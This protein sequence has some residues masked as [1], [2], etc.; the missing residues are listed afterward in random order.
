MWLRHCKRKMSFVSMLFV[1]LGFACRPLAAG[2]RIPVI[3]STDIGNEIDDQWMV[4]YALTSPELDVLGIVSAHAPM[5]SPPAG[6]TSYRILVDVVENRLGMNEHP[7]LFAGAS[8]P[9]RDAQTPRPNAGVDFII[10]ASKSFSKGNRLNVLA[11]GAVTDVASALLEDPAMADRIQIVNMGF[12]DWPNGEDD[13]NILNDVTAMQVILGSGTPLVVGSARVCRE[14]LGLTVDQARQMIGDRGPVG[15][16]LWEEFQAF[17]YRFEKPMRKNDLTKPK[18]IW[19]IVV[20]AYILGM[21]STEIHP[22]PIMKDDATFEHVP[23]KNT[24]TWITKIEERRLWADFLD[25][26]DRYQRSHAVGHS[27]ITTRYTFLMP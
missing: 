7:P 15:E 4:V 12:R 21:T 14:H 16:W 10:A 24:I 1:V 18:V 2:Q 6:R 23:T 17:Y 13:F 3:L 25:K 11:T 22:R 5:L 20:V 27:P 9:L 26:L 8:Q 19:D